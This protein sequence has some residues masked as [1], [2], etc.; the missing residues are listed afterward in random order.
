MS[1][2]PVVYLNRVID[3]ERQHRTANDSA[4][5]SLFLMG[6]GDLIGTI[7]CV[8]GGVAA[9]VVSTEAYDQAKSNL[10][11]S[12]YFATREVEVLNPKSRTAMQYLAKQQLILDKNQESKWRLY[13]VASLTF[14]IFLAILI[15]SVCIESPLLLLLGLA[16]L[17]TGLVVALVVFIRHETKDNLL[18][19]TFKEWLPIATKLRHVLLQQ[20][21]PTEAE[22]IS[23]SIGLH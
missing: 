8:A 20:R 5:G 14:I 7:V 17:I 2:D 9:T 22:K 13:L 3:Q 19:N 18:W 11:E 21:G 15:A 10:M 12:S 1:Y 16:G 6:G 23:A 4:G